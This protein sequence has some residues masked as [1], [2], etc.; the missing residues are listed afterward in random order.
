M[1]WFIIGL[2]VATILLAP[3]YP[4]LAEHMTLV[5]PEQATPQMATRSSP[6]FDV[7]VTLGRDGF[8]LG[9]R[10]FSAV[11]VYG[12]WLNGQSRPDGFSVDGRLQHPDRA[13]NFKFN[14]DID[15]WARRALD[16]LT[17]P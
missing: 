8:R 12:A 17:A 6:T 16:P 7:G 15:A 9:A 13:F 3:G 2:T 4:A 11:G 14:A 10:L 1:K 5:A